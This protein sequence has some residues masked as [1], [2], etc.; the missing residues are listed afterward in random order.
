LHTV[1]SWGSSTPGEVTTS[2]V[3]EELVDELRTL[4]Y[5]D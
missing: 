1:P 2:T 4:G 3:D 5:L